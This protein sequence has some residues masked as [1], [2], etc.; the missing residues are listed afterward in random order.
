M[1]LTTEDA[2]ELHQN[3]DDIFSLPRKIC[4]EEKTKKKYDQEV[5]SIIKL[6]LTFRYILQLSHYNEQKN[7]KSSGSKI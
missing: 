6:I 2:L 1:V 4:K 3:D 5:N 7:T